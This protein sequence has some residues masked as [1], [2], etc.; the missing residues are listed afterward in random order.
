MPDFNDP[1]GTELQPTENCLRSRCLPSVI[2]WRLMLPFWHRS[3]VYLAASPPGVRGR[4]PWAWRRACRLSPWRS[5]PRRPSPDRWSRSSRLPSGACPP[6]SAGSCSARPSGRS[7]WV[8]PPLPRSTSCSAPQYD[9]SSRSW[10]RKSRNTRS[11]RCW[12]ELKK[13]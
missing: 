8:G 6:G 13:E 3:L 10:R 12:K 7:T 9:G 4:P 5:S 1:M 2:T 11:R